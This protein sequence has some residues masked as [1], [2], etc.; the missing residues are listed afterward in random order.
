MSVNHSSIHSLLLLRLMLLSLFTTRDA[1]HGQCTVTLDGVPER[2]VGTLDN[3]AL[4]VIDIVDMNG[5]VLSN[6]HDGLRNG[7]SF[8]VP[9]VPDG[10]FE[11][12]RFIVSS[13]LLSLNPTC[14]LFNSAIPPPDM[15]VE[16]FTINGPCVD[17]GTTIDFSDGTLPCHN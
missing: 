4:A 10:S 7:Q 13:G 2:M 3:N 17:E 11:M 1:V 15:D 9:N 14:G 8:D 6:N 16:M 12:Y 5:D